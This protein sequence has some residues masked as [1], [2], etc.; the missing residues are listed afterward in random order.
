MTPFVTQSN[1]KCVVPSNS[2][3]VSLRHFYLI[4]TQSKQTVS[5]KPL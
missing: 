4:R 2:E 5:L 1:N 3:E